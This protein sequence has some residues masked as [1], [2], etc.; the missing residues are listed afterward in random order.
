VAIALDFLCSAAFGKAW[1]YPQLNYCEGFAIDDDLLIAVSH[2]WLINDA[3]EVVDPTWT[4]KM[5]TGCTYFGVV[6]NH[7]FVVNFITKTR[8][9]GI[10]ESDYLNDYQLLQKGFPEGA[11]HTK[12]HT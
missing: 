12:F 6:L 10:L 1:G 7:N 2:A 8:H 3:F 4:G 11:L 9:Y 5:F